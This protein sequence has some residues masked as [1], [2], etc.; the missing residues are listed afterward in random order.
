M[1]KKFL[2][3]FGYQNKFD[4]LDLT[5]DQE[6]CGAILIE[7]E[8]E[9]LAIEWGNIISDWYVANINNGE[10]LPQWNNSNFANWIENENNVDYKWFL[11]NAL[12]VKYGEYPNLVAL[13]K[14][15]ND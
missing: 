12:C 11:N 10:S 7:T 2:Y 9:S 8:S 13:K 5:L 4:K 1:I 15:H 3:R 14:F 6:S